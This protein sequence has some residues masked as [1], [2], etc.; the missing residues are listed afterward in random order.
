MG[1][2]HR[3]GGQAVDVGCVDER[4]AIGA[5]VGIAVVV[6]NEEDDVGSFGV[7]SSMQAAGE[8]H[9]GG[10]DAGLRDAATLDVVGLHG[11]LGST[12]EGLPG[13]AAKIARSDRAGE[14]VRMEFYDL[15]V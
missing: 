9:D 7:F 4:V 11:W 10:Y 13:D 14:S 5:R 8:K 3:L 1:E 6:C 15:S 2:T 12:R